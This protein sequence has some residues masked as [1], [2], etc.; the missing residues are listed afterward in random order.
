[1]ISHFLHELGATK[2]RKTYPQEESE[3]T[4]KE[5]SVRFKINFFIVDANEEG[6]SLLVAVMN[7][8]KV[9]SI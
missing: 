2:D 8:K 6:E 1:M 3:N 4:N 5:S 9:I 7:G